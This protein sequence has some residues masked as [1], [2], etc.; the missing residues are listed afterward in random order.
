MQKLIDFA[1]NVYSQNGEDGIVEK[2]FSII[3]PNSKVCVEFGAWDGFHLSNSANLWSKK[4][5]QGVLIELNADRFKE[6]VENT[7]Q[8]DCRC[9]N[10]RVEGAGHCTL[11]NILK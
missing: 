3:G 11:E 1:S 6:L 9:I 7:K 5:W 8:F 4:G 2:I 10:A